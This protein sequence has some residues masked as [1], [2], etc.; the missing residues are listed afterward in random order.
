[1]IKGPS[2]VEEVAKSKYFDKL[3]K[4][5]SEVRRFSNGEMLSCIVLEQNTVE[6]QIFI[7]V[8]TLLKDHFNIA[9]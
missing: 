3:F 6:K 2:V 1:M 4:N 5:L 7:I 8:K 9:V